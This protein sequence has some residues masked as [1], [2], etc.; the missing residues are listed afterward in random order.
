M[1]TKSDSDEKFCFQLLSKTLTCTLHLRQRESNFT[2]GYIFFKK[3]PRRATPWRCI[4]L[5]SLYNLRSY[6]TSINTRKSICSPCI[7]NR[8]KHW[9][10]STSYLT[11]MLTWEHSIHFCKLYGEERAG[12]FAK[13]V[14][15]V[16]RDG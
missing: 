3:Y 1:P 10:S 2:M 12:C 15:L 11:K 4:H 7:N 5:K 6:V 8:V 13:F 14:L 16:S 9:K